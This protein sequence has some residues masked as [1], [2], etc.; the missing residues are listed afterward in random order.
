MSTELAAVCTDAVFNDLSSNSEYLPRLQLFGA[1]STAVK[2]GAVPMANYALVTGKESFTV[3]GPTAD[4]FPVAWRPK[5]MDVGGD[6]VVAVY[7]IT[8][9]KFKEIRERST[10]ESDSGCMFGPEFLV[11]VAGHGFATLYMASKSARREAPSIRARLNTPVTL[12]AEFIKTN[13]YS[14]HAIKSR[15]CSTPFDLPSE[16]DTAKTTYKFLNP[17]T[18]EFVETDDRAR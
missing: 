7:D 1:N 9:E 13:R 15:A 3:L 17:T 10:Q 6:D 12:S 14:W 4:I 18:E 8:S 2:S 11:Y 16:E 5:A